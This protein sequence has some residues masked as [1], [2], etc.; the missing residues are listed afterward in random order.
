MRKAVK[1]RKNTF[2]SKSQILLQLSPLI[3]FSLMIDATVQPFFCRNK[4]K[5]GRMSNMTVY[6]GVSSGINERKRKV[7]NPFSAIKKERGKV[8]SKLAVFKLLKCEILKFYSKNIHSHSSSY[9]FLHPA[10]YSWWHT[11]G[12]KFT[13]CFLKEDFN[14]S[15]EEIVILS[16]DYLWRID[17]H[18]EDASLMWKMISHH[19]N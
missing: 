3:V 9:S 6:E 14:C 19:Q 7:Q 15:S 11:E 18:P 4:I 16:R 2:E 17:N 12:Q 13:F 8:N 10:I 1:M 5:I